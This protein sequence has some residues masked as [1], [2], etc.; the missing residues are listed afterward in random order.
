MKALV[1]ED[2]CCLA[3]GVILTENE[4]GVLYVSSQF[5]TRVGVYVGVCVCIRAHTHTVQLGYSVVSPGFGMRHLEG[6]KNP[7]G[8]NVGIHTFVYVYKVHMCKYMLGGGMRSWTNC[9]FLNICFLLKQK[10]K[11]C[12]RKPL[13]IS[14]LNYKIWAHGPSINGI[15]PL[16]ISNKSNHHHHGSF[17]LARSLVHREGHSLWCARAWRVCVFANVMTDCVFFMSRL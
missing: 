8:L 11:R 14:N 13:I 1:Y 12:E 6:P 9:F 10:S 2:T 4:I 17:E 15:Q 3:R 7:D 5:S 16:F